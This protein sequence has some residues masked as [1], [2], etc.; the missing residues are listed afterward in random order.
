[1]ILEKFKM[2]SK[3]PISENDV[4]LAVIFKS[5]EKHCNP[6]YNISLVN[7][8]SESSVI[9][10]QTSVLLAPE[11]EVPNYLILYF[12]IDIIEFIFLYF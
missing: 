3:R 7:L 9:K 1:M 6:Y 11:T 12:L 5:T 4:G 8:Q 10:S 2:M